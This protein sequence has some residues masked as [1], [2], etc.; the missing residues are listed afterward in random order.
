MGIRALCFSQF[1]LPIA[2]HHP[3]LLLAKPLHQQLVRQAP[4]FSHQMAHRFPIIKIVNLCY[5]QYQ[6]MDAY[7][8]VMQENSRVVGIKKHA[9]RA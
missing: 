5:H 1:V 8:N 4:L 9:A 7:L 6:R 3:G 2:K